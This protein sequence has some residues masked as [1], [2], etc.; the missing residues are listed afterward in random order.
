MCVCG[1]VCVC[2]GVG[3]G[4]GVWVYDVC[5]CVKGSVCVYGVLTVVDVC[6]EC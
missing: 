6:M 4:V 1:C 2:V 5:G 3:V